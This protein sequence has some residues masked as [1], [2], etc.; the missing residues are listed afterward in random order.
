MICFKHL[1]A[2]ILPFAIG[3]VLL[4]NWC[5]T[6]S[7]AQ[8][9]PAPPSWASKVI[10][11]GASAEIINRHSTELAGWDN[12]IQKLRAT[13]D[14]QVVSISDMQLA[15]EALGI[16]QSRIRIFIEQLSPEL[17]R[18][19]AQLA[20]LGAAPKEPEKEADSLAAQ[21]RSITDEVTAYDGVI[22]RAEILFVQANQTIALYN[23][24]RRHRF[25][26]E[27]LKRPKRFNQISYWLETLE[28]LPG[29][30]A[31]ASAI[32]RDWINTKITESSHR[33]IVVL[34]LTILS[35]LGLSVL[36]RR[37][38]R[39]SSSTDGKLLKSRAERGTIVLRR[40]LSVS[41]PIFG[42]FAVLYLAASS[43]DFLSNVELQILSRGLTYLA[44][45]TF[46]I[47]AL[48]F[49][50]L[51]DRKRERFIRI[52]DRSARPVFW[53]LSFLIVAWL[54]DQTIALMD[55]AFETP[56][57]VIVLRSVF[58][59]IIYAT[60]LFCL[61]FVRIIRSG[62]PLATRQTNGWPR[63][64]YG[65]IAIASLTILSS[66]VL[67]YASLARFLGSQIVAT[68]GLLAIVSLVHLT[69]EHVSTP[70]VVTARDESSP[71]RTTIVG[72]TLGVVLG[73]SLDLLVLLIGLPVLLLQWGYEWN[74]VSGWVSSAFFGFQVGGLKLSIQ[75]IFIGIGI[76]VVGVSLTRIV[77]QMFW[78]R[79]E[80]VFAEESGAR[81]S[82]AKILT[83][84]GF[85]LSVL[86]ALSYLGVGV[87][88]LAL[89]AGALSIGIGFGLQ[90]IIN[91]FVSGLILLTE[92]T[93]KTGDWII[94]GQVEGF[95]E[96]INVRSTEVRTFDRSTVI[97]PNAD[98]IT[99]Q[100][101]NWTYGNK[102]GRVVVNVGVSYD[103]D[104]EQ[105]YD[106][107]ME[108]ARSHPKSMDKPGPR[109]VFTDFGD[110]ALMFSLRV[111][112][113]DIGDSFS[114][115]TGVRNMIW[116]RFRE[117]GIE[118]AYPQRNLHI[119]DAGPL[120][121]I[122]SRGKTGNEAEA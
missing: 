24:K 22:K 97:V 66:G 10:A 15:T 70:K 112:I 20:R 41:A 21:R 108:I 25:M 106:L 47:V 37:L 40:T 3:I 13:A 61:L 111:Y 83:Y 84:T 16:I 68:G 87:S 27:L 105:V 65:A 64:V 51:P 88:N 14:R 55:Q 113:A 67:G 77:R 2:A 71:D 5:V 54:A 99:G 109:C 91:N 53:I 121:G 63:W 31:R 32:G 80:H 59:A 34:T 74:E 96:R 33:F 35:A 58:V 9:K 52:H 4:T 122:F 45:A 42:T 28:S 49:A 107:L 119:K 116:K 46:I 57:S 26:S 6:S 50:L 92:R 117:E 19:Q 120:A 104:P 75:S 94:L 7:Q 81:E 86:G 118:I 39:S 101:T 98:L 62:S 73:I 115:R 12:A 85:V 79:T 36:F 82:I 44:V 69:A 78:R 100:V 43:F 56:L 48:R 110:S 76:F 102:I 1:L 17:A 60:L 8:D 89:V 30:V 114:V 93:I 38:L 23:A 18:S 11:A 29:E 72:A 95:V 90:S 103:S